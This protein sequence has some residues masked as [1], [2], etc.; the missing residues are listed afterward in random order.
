MPCEIGGKLENGCALRMVINTRFLFSGRGSSARLM[1]ASR[2]TPIVDFVNNFKEQNNLNN[3]QVNPVLAKAREVD[4]LVRRTVPAAQRDAHNANIDAKMTEIST[5]LAA[6]S[7]K[8][9]T[10]NQ[11]HIRRFAAR[12]WWCSTG[13]LFR[14]SPP[15]RLCGKQQ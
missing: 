4:Q 2:P 14:Q 15:G 11:H 5:A 1:V 10:C 3:T 12:V 9:C 7:C 8:F 13:Q 6:A